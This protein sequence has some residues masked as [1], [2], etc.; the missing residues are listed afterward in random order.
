MSTHQ[1]KPKVVNEAVVED[2]GNIFWQHAERKA[3]A[4]PP[5]IFEAMVSPPSLK[6][7][8]GQ[9]GEMLTDMGEAL[10]I[11]VRGDVEDAVNTASRTLHAVRNLASQIWE[12]KDEHGFPRQ[13]YAMND[14]TTLAKCEVSGE[15]EQ[16]N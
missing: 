15:W 12:E 16:L 2:A 14:G 10:L 8:S 9:A 7:A 13:C 4:P 11:Y 1:G 3:K 6:N 5:V